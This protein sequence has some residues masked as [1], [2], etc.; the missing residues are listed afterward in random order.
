MRILESG[1][2]LPL[3]RCGLALICHFYLVPS[4]LAPPNPPPPPTPTPLPLPVQA[5]CSFQLQRA[6]SCDALLVATAAD[7]AGCEEREEDGAGMELAQLL[8]R[9]RAQCNQGRPAG[10][11]ERRGGSAPAYSPSSGPGLG[12]AAAAVAAS[13][14]HGGAV[15]EV[16]SHSCIV[17]LLLF[18]CNCHSVLAHRQRDT[19]PR[20]L[21][22]PTVRY[23]LHLGD[24]SGLSGILWVMLA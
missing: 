9:I 21:P 7:A 1:P 11:G 17:T 20:D 24:I 23:C 16:C 12:H 2:P 18:F 10:P 3:F 14:E 4:P 8:D 13:R 5:A 6:S 22:Q 19:R 15:I